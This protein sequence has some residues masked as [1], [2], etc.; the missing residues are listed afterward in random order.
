MN[1]YQLYLYY[2]YYLNEI[3]FTKTFLSLFSIQLVQYGDVTLE[4]IAATQNHHHDDQHADGAN[5][6]RSNY[7]NAQSSPLTIHHHNQSPSSS[8][9]RVS[10][11]F[12]VG[13]SGSATAC[14]NNQVNYGETFSEKIL[15][16]P[17]VPG[18]PNL[19]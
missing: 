14:D 18:F 9:F 2:D 7:K 5:L 13:R 4:G 6:K 19:L 10:G 16:F 11:Y 8:D 3:K 1:S 15:I 17:K 12:L